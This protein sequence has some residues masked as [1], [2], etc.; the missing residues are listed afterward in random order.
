M[1]LGTAF[2]LGANAAGVPSLEVGKE[3]MQLW[4]DRESGMESHNNRSQSLSCIYF[5]YIPRLPFPIFSMKIVG[6]FHGKLYQETTP[7]GHSLHQAP[8]YHGT[9]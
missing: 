9:A 8:S 4:R 3:E 7:Y 5:V 1:C 6:R 2:C